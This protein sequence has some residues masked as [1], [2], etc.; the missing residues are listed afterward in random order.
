MTPHSFHVYNT[1]PAG[2]PWEMGERL[3]SSQ[4]TEVVVMDLRARAPVTATPL[5]MAHFQGY[6]R[7]M[8]TED[9]RLCTISGKFSLGSFTD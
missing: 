8:D 3:F 5:S 9:S 4:S 7:S 1:L 6:A 2:M